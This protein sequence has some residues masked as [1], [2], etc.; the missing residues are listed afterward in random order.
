LLEA[1]KITE[2]NTALRERERERER[3]HQRRDWH[4]DRKKERKRLLRTARGKRSRRK[5]TVEPQQSRVR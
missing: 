5:T 3:E 2:N 1:R 4:G